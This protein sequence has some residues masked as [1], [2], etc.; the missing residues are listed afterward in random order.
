MRFKL[1]FFSSLS[2]DVQDLKYPITTDLHSHLLPGLDDGAKDMQE[3]IEL[4]KA[5][6]SIG[7]QRAITTPHVMQDYYKNDQKLILQTLE[8]VRKQLEI[9]E[10][11]FVLDAS[12]EYYLDEALF[13][14][15]QYPEQLLFFGQSKNLLLFELSFMNEPG[16][17]RDFCFN[18]QLKGYQLILAHPERYI[19][20]QSNK[21]KLE[22]LHE[23]GVWFQLNVNSLSGYYSLEAKKLAEWLIDQNMIDFVGT[24]CHGPKHLKAMENLKGNKYFKRIID[25]PLKHSLL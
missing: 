18:A 14:K 24:D 19:Y 13:E 4:I 9:N 2:D 3:S 20:F 15:I 25:L 17:L 7:I 10:I 12:A 1:P 22:Q 5:L 6:K 8:A 21:S 16:M 23:S 11:D